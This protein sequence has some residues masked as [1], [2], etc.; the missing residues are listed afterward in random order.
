MSKKKVIAFD[1]ETIADKT[2]LTMLPEVK[3]NGRL[4]DPTKIAADIKEK[5][6]KQKEEMGLSP[7]LNMICC[8]GWCDEN[9]VGSIMLENESPE[10]EKKLLLKFWEVL[11][12]YDHFITFNGRSF[13]MRCML[14]HGMSYGIRPSVN[15]DKGK[16]NKGN[17]TDLRGILAGEGQFA[18]GKMEFFAQKYLGYGKTEDIDGAQVQSYWDMGLTED[19]AKYCE[20]DC[21]ITLDLYKMAEIA[22]MLE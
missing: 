15:I 1:L 22:G 17:H 20:E 18:K 21:M 6:E 5:Q 12:D 13:D 2:M 14:L 16:Y 10:A 11:G 9:G 8:A 3:A 4:K 19:I 7:M